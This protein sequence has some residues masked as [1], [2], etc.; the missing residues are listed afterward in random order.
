[1]ISIVS[2]PTVSIQYNQDDGYLASLSCTACNLPSFTFPSASTVVTAFPKTPQIG[3]RQ[4]LAE[5]WL[6]ME[7]HEIGTY[8]HMEKRFLMCNSRYDIHFKM[9]PIG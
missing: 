3:I 4:E 2:F 5:K 9:D 7:N 1:M 6:N 8:W